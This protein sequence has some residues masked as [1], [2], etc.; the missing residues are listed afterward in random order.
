MF[1]SHSF[2][3]EC[4][5]RSNMHMIDNDHMIFA[6]GNMLQILNIKTKQKRYIRSI[7]SGGIGALAVSLAK[8]FI[9][10]QSLM[11]VTRLSE[12]AP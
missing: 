9:L 11:S 3:F 1:K 8:L 12:N 2:G 6:A 7:K 10:K 4:T 5:K